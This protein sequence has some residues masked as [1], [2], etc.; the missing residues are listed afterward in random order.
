MNAHD[1]A[2]DLLHG[3]VLDDG[4]RW[5]A[6][7]APWQVRDAEA[8]LSPDGPRFSFIDRP[9]GG[10]KTTDVGGVAAVLLACEAPPGARCYA[11]SGDRDQAGLL[12]DAV[13]GLVN[14]TP[15]LAEALVVD[16]SKVTNTVTGATLEV[17]AADGWS[18]FGLKPWLV[19]VDELSAW[20]ATPNSERLWE[21][22]STSLGKVPGAR[23]VVITNAGSPASLAGQV[24]EHAQRSKLWSV[25]S[26]PGPLPW[27]DEEFLADERAR[28]PES[29]YRRLHLN[30][31]VEGEDSLASLDDVRA[32]AVLDGPLAYREGTRYVIGADLGLFHDQTVVVVAH[33]EDVHATEGSP[34]VNGHRVVVDRLQTWQGSKRVPVDLQ[35]VEDYIA[36]C[37]REYGHAE[38]IGDMWQF[39]STD[40][41]LQAR[42]LKVTAVQPSQATTGRLGSLLHVLIRSHGL[43]IPNDAGLIDELANVRLREVPGGL[44]LDHLPGRHDDQA[45]AIALAADRLLSAAP[46]S[47]GGSISTGEYVSAARRTFGKGDLHVQGARYLDRQADGSLAPPPGWREGAPGPPPE[48]PPLWNGDLRMPRRP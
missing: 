43:A 15:A 45:F 14:R 34:V 7:A 19:V 27:V 23:A 9:R 5:G 33:R 31:W 17:I 12:L 11:A 24:R 36:M 1:R 16:A 20:P 26:T 4:R 40:Q 44:R 6:V 30:E 48:R 42:G 47:G 29:S 22:L 25:R 18:A 41:R 3:L 8:V 21:A 35:A 13:R 32:C 28:L 37:S 2:R 10:S 39:A 46:P 38:V